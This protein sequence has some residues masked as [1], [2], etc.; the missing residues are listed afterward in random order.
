[1]MWFQEASMSAMCCA[2]MNTQASASDIR[3][4]S[5]LFRAAQL[6]LDRHKWFLSEKAGCDMG[7]AAI[8]NWKCKHWWS[9]CRARLVEHLSGTKYWSELDQHDYDLI[10]R[11]FHPNRKLVEAIFDRVKLGGHYGENL[12]II[13]WA[14]AAGHNMKEVDEILK[15]IDINSKRLEFFLEL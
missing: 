12:G 2:I 8:K 11:E 6:E 13:L 4:E 1:M 15:L 3:R 7:Q 14:Q 5:E 9:W 10:N